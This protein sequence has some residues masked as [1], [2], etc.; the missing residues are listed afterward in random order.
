MIIAIS[1]QKGGVGKTTTSAA[2]S[3]AIANQTKHV[4]L[5]DLDPQANLTMM[6]ANHSPDTIPITV[7]DVLAKVIDDRPISPGEGIIKIDDYIDLLPSNI[8]LSGLETSLVNAMSRENILKTY[9]SEI[10]HKYDYVIIDCMP[11][12]GMLTI[13]A[14][15][16]SDSVIIPVQPHFLSAKGLEL[17]LRTIGKVRRQINP[18]LKVDGILMTMVDK[19]TNFTR[20]IMNLLQETY[21]DQIRIFKSEIPISI[22]AVEASA[23][24]KSIFEYD[25]K[26]KVAIAYDAF[27]KEVMDHEGTKQKNRPDPV[28]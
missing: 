10:K 13:N 18:N 23:D 16:T 17:L 1:N 12:L 3:A 6:L 15:A 19:R 2:L 24:G 14:L 9:L 11:S 26:G 20:E 25:P 21:G 5:V 28:R 22:R 27:A 4:L 8:Q 7:A